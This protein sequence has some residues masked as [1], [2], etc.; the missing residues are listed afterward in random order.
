MQ[1]KADNLTDGTLSDVI[2]K[3]EDH[4][5]I[6][7]IR[8]NINKNFTFSF[9]LVTSDEIEKEINQLNI[10]KSQSHKDIFTK[11]IKDNRDIFSNLI[12]YNCN[13]GIYNTR[14]HT[15]LKKVGFKSVSVPKNNLRTNKKNYR[16][17]SVIPV[18][19]K[20]YERLI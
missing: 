11:I 2:R 12:T 1:N 19:S 20:V 9:S 17:V 8:E 13:S 10:S 3:S 16:P 6:M 18:I 7:K 4:P 5:S 14:F 15:F